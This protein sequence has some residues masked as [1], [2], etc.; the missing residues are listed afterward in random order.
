[1]ANCGIMRCEKR[2]MQA[3][4]GIH[5]ENNRDAEKQKEFVASDIDWERTPDNVFFVKSDNFKADIEKELHDYGIDKWRKDA[6][7][8]IDGL[9]TA[10][11][12]FFERKT[13]KQ[14]S[15]YFQ[16]CLEY[17]KD[18]YGD[19]IINAVVH[20]DEATPHMHVVSVP[21]VAKAPKVELD[22]NGIPKPQ[23]KSYKL[24]AKDLM[25][26]LKEYYA[27][28]DSFY[29]Q[30]SKQYGLE[31]GETRNPEQRR[32]HLT[33]LEYKEQQVGETL[34]RS[35]EVIEQNKADA[36]V[37]QKKLEEKQSKAEKLDK[38]INGKEERLTAIDGEIKAAKELR[39]E[40]SDKGLF[41]RVKDEITIPYSEYRSL[42]KTARA[43]ED[44]KTKESFL[45]SR[46]RQINADRDNIQPRLDQVAEMERIAKEKHDKAQEY[47]D[48]QENYILGTADKLAKKKFDNFMKQHYHGH[49]SMYEDICEY[50]RDNFSDADKIIEDFEKWEREQE[51]Q[52]TQEWSR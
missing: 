28:Q 29:E 5:A 25:G 31:R 42:Q 7:T 38:Q 13:N 30:V 23:N 17:H 34:Q 43:V 6:V 46:E 2:K 11:P 45:N 41:G 9:Y 33:V 40:K 4:G 36:I 14:I 1:M 51:I 52:L 24:S 50:L 19:H 12:E 49:D 44:T 18:T 26:G 32:E 35:H 27:R 21:I 48:K 39:K 16:S 8:F 15:D 37:I 47:F 20:L 22:D 3:C 10:S